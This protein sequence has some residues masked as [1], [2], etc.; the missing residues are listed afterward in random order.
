MRAAIKLAAGQSRAVTADLWHIGVEP[1]CDRVAPSG[2]SGN[3]TSA[4]SL[5]LPV[6]TSQLNT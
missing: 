4:G 3:V 6:K 2:Q 1:H 5:H